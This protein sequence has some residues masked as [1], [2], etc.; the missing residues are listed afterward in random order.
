M[1]AVKF[2]GHNTVFGETQ[3]QYQPLPALQLPDGTVITCWKLSDQEIQDIVQNRC[4]YLKQLIFGQQ[5]QPILPMTDLSD[6]L[7]LMLP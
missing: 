5:L 4:F 2:S 7:E 3:L 6:G 1:I